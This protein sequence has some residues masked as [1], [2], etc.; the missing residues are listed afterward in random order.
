MLLDGGIENVELEEL[1]VVEAGCFVK[2]SGWKLSDD[3]AADDDDD[4]E[5]AEVEASVPD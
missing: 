4:A 3:V 5:E 1:A 2:I